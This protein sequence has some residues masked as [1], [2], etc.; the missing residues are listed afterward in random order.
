MRLFLLLLLLLPTAAAAADRCATPRAAMTT[1]IDNLQ[2]EIDRPQAA[3]ECFDW[4]RGPL[5]LAPRTAVARDLLSVLDGRGH[6]VVYS[7]VPDEP[8]HKTDGE[9]R[10]VPFQTLPE[11]YLQRI[12]GRWVVSADSVAAA[13]TL[14]GQTFRVP[15]ERYA[16]QLGLWAQTSIL[17]T[18]AWRWLGLLALV[19]LALGV[20]KASG[21][22]LV[23]AV[24]RL[25]EQF[26]DHWDPAIEKRILRRGGWLLAAGLVAVGLPNLGLGVRLNQ[27]G[28]LV[29]EGIAS[30]L[31]V[32]IGTAIV[33]L[34]FDAWARR[35]EGTETRMD[36]QLIPLLGRAAKGAVWV[37]GLLFVLQNLNVNVA[38]LIAGLGLG[39]LAFALAAQDTLAHF[40][41]SLTIFADRPFQIGDWVTVGGVEGTVEEVGFRSTRVR[42]FHDSL[43]TIPN[44]EVAGAV[45]DNMG[46]RRFRRFKTKLTLTYD[47]TPDQMKAFVEGVRAT[48]AASP[49]TRKDAYEVFFHSM[50]ATS[51]DVLVYC[52]F[53][54]ASWREELQG[55]QSLQLQWMRLAEE[56]GVSW[57]FPTQTLH[58]ESFGDQTRAGRPPVPVTPT[59]ASIVDEFG[60]GG[61]QDQAIEPLSHG[62]WPASAAE[63][64]SDDGE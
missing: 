16:Q 46:Q 31:A 64:G 43:V 15:L 1:W 9:S 55:R 42:T 32:L 13:P 60:P 45:V 63:R 54:V 12:D 24:R 33:D 11:L 7:Q 35:T 27:F 58:V 53:D 44:S 10:Y 51:L 38:S 49:Y 25:L 56:L 6:F 5:G 23:R 40:F 62:W 2:P 50:S 22:V 61:A 30:V 47:T 19:L 8:G 57:A 21:L 3:I 28:L 36:D 52:F 17:G 34:V 37:L 59:L 26:I 20:G 39:G 14:L 48:V 41:G 29:T 4:S 18:E